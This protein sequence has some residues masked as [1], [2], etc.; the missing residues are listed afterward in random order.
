MYLD[1][2][3]NVVFAEFYE[4]VENAEER[5]SRVSLDHRDREAA[6]QYA[7]DLAARFRKEATP[8]RAPELTLG[9]LFDIYDREVTP[10]KSD[11]KEK[12]D[13]R[14]RRLF[15]HC[16]A[17]RRSSPGWIAVT[18]IDSSVTAGREG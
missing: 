10:F 12:H 1:P 3:R 11:G 14:A 9:S 8:V 17:V 5:C 13:R 6:K 4:R 16:W 15:E 18:G 2:S 7:D